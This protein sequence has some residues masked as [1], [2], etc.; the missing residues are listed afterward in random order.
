MMM[1]YTWTM[2]KRGIRMKIDSWANLLKPDVYTGREGQA[3][4]YWETGE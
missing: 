1:D 3:M 2:S 4:F